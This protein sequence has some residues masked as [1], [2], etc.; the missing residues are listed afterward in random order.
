MQRLRP[1]WLAGCRLRPCYFEPT[2]HKHA[3][4]SCAGLQIHVDDGAY[5]PE[6][7][8]P[9]RLVTLFLKAVRTLT[10]DTPCGGTLLTSM[11]PAVWRS[12]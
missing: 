8:S 9:Y 5:R 6:A 3:G 7:F 11:K 10:P 4:Q 12:T 1:E 2:F